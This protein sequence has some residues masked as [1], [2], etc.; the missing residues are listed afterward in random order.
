M[1]KQSALIRLPLLCKYAH[2]M[3]LQAR[4]IER[5]QHEQGENAYILIGE[6]YPTYTL[7]RREHSNCSS[8]A[9]AL[10]LDNPQADVICVGRG[11]QVTYHG[12]GQLCLYPIMDMRKLNATAGLHWYSD[13]LVGILKKAIESLGFKATDRCT[14]VHTESGKVGFVGFQVSRWVTS[15]GISL[16]VDSRSVGGFE[17]IVPCG[18]KTTR[19]AALNVGM[20]Q[21]EDALLA[22][23]CRE[24]QMPSLY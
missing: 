1:L 3:S 13:R 11:G 24:F 10:S 17:A 6:H 20:E 4:L 15:Y 2:F 7:G 22:S 23:F 8:I 9:E 5:V 16:N 19:I 14:G 18:D 21:A 12:P